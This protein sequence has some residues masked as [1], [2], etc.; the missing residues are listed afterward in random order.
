MNDT[1]TFALIVIAAL[2]LV[3]FGLWLLRTARRLDRLHKALTSC[4]HV[5]DIHLVQRAV[6]AQQL[7]ASGALDPATSLVLADAA[8]KALTPAG[9]VVADGFETKPLVQSRDV[10]HGR[11]RVESSLTA[12]LRQL[13]ERDDVIAAPAWHDVTRAWY[14]A[15]LARTFH[16]ARLTAVVRLRRHPLVRMF[17]LAGKAPIPLTFDGDLTPPPTV[18]LALP[19]NHSPETD[20]DGWAIGPSG[21]LER[22]AARIVLV[23]N[24]GYV[25]VMRG[26]DKD[27][28]EHCWWFT[29][30][31]GLLA[32][33]DPRGALLREV[34]EETGV[35]LSAEQLI[36][37]VATRSAR[38]E[39]LAATRIQHEQFFFA[40]L[41]TRPELSSS[42]WTETE[43]NVLDEMRWATFTELRERTANGEVL[44]PR[45][46]IA[47]AERLYREGWDGTVTIFR[48]GNPH[49]GVHN[50]EH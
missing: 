50:A 31:G 9:V 30:G 35:Q 40:T 14:Y 1:L 10:Q 46:F 39:F 44:Y 27:D 43:R 16:D 5:L 17:H 13:A 8:N 18:E 45:G 37:P 21:L 12:V 29:P 25:L 15:Q 3:I 11:A 41:P 23:T 2:A 7:A 32:G 6:A 26:H 4:R 19:A 47:L 28:H 48:D 36:G 34:R 38:F 49:R 24:D 33:E 20:A 42:Q 22:E